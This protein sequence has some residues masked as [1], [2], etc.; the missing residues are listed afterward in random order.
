MAVGLRVSNTKE[1]KEPTRYFSKKQE[2]SVAKALGGK[3]QANS[4]ATD[5]KKSDVIIKNLM[6]IEC[7]TKTKHSNSITIKKEWVDKLKQ[8]SLFNGT[9][10]STVAFSFGPDEENYYIIY[11]ELFVEFIDFLK[12]KYNIE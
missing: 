7:K 11:D 1:E 9:R 12:E 5:W 2:T 8:E 10:F 4:G 6:S 3:R